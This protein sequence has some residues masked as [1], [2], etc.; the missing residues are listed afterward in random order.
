MTTRSDK[1]LPLWAELL[2]ILATIYLVLAFDIGDW[3]WPT[4]IH[5]PGKEALIILK[6]CI[7][8]G[9]NNSLKK[10]ND[11]LKIE[12]KKLRNL[13]VR[14]V[15][16]IDTVP[17]DCKVI[18]PIKVAPIIKKMHHRKHSFR[19][20]GRGVYDAHHYLNEPPPCGCPRPIGNPE[21][22]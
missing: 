22:Y 6:P 12:N 17:G 20:N 4:Q 9:I 11:S 5:R 2:I 10:S 15:T 1:R 16:K 18:V 13:P 19:S 21:S 14:I 8:D 3:K 7:A